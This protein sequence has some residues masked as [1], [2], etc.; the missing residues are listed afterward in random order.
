M[1][2]GEQFVFFGQTRRSGRPSRRHVF[3]A[4]P[5]TKRVFTNELASRVN[6]RRAERMLDNNDPAIFGQDEGTFRWWWL[7][8]PGCIPQ[9]DPATTLQYQPRRLHLADGL[10]K[11]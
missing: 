3:V 5:R 9:I 11:T 7:G 1:M 10:L 6:L 4:H 8:I 2:Q